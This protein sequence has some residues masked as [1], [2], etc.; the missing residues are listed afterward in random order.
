MTVV[1]LVAT[2]LL[3]V[4]TAITPDV[5]SYAAEPAPRG[6]LTTVDETP[7]AGSRPGEGRARPGRA[8]PPVPD[9]PPAPT[10]PPYV[11]PPRPEP[12]AVSHRDTLSDAGEPPTE[13]VLPGLRVLP[14]GGGLVLIGLGLGFLGL[15]LRRGG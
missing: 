7:R 12:A 14:L 13:P 2:T 3:T 5:P 8:D 6:P 4:L 15:R 11:P 10:P 1:A 9:P